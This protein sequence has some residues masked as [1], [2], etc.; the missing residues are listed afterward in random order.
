MY[1]FVAP[2]IELFSLRE[3]VQSMLLLQNFQG[4]NHRILNA[5]PS[6]KAFVF[7]N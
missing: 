5:T 3:T 7:Q 2:A 4:Y 6:R 1:G